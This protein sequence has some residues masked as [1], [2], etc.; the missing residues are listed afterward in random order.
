MAVCRTANCKIRTG[1]VRGYCP[2]CIQQAKTASKDNAEYPC[3]K[4]GNNVEKLDK[5]VCCECCSVWYHIV[6]ADIDAGTYDILFD[7]KVKGVRWYCEG[8][9]N[10]VDEALE[11]LASIEAQTSVLKSDMSEVKEKISNLEKAV[12]Q[13]IDNTVHEAIEEKREIEHRKMNLIVYGL[14]EPE[15]PDSTTAWD[16][17]TMIEADTATISTL[18]T[19]ELGVGLSPNKGIAAARRLGMKK[20]GKPRPLRITFND[21]VV[22]RDVLRNSMKLRQ[23]TAHK[24]VYINP[25]LTPKQ[26][27]AEL[28]LVNE[29]WKQ[30]EELGKKVIIK[31][32]ELVEVD[33]DLLMKR[34]IKKPTQNK[35]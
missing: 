7:S 8:C 11:K 12:K 28:E 9:E 34:P 3:G 1:L 29:M 16:T 21:I 30:R 24:Y 15:K 2:K 33:R 17:E 14:T 26:R 19:S 5:A 27:K 31:K 18:I 25:D 10:K 35:A 4:C 32:G 6:C 13:Q 20:V 22:K 23:V